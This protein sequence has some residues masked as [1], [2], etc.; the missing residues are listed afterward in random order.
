MQYTLGSVTYAGPVS[1]GV[2]YQAWKTSGVSLWTFQDAPLEEQLRWFAAAVAGWLSSCGR[3]TP[4]DETLAWPMQQLVQAGNLLLADL[5]GDLEPIV[6]GGGSAD[7][8][9]LAPGSG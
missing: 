2:V 1:T 4:L 9:P 6:A 5:V 7:A 8:D 3:Q